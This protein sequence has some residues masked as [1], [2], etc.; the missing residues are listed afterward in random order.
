MADFSNNFQMSYDADASTC[1]LRFRCFDTPNSVTVHGCA[2]PDYEAERVLLDV[3]RTCL[4]LHRLWSFSLAGSDVSRINAAC[5]RV[6]VDRRTA[7]LI[8]AMKDFHEREP[9]FDFTIGPVSY[10]WK[11]AESV[12]GDDEL[13]EALSHVGA[14]LVSVEGGTVVKADPLAQ[15]DVGGAAKGFAADEIVRC[16][17]DAG[18]SCADVD[19]GGNLFM[20][21]SHPSGRDWRVAVRI[22]EGVRAQPVV[23]RVNDKSVVTSGSYERFVEIEGVRYQHIIDVRTGW[24]AR[25]DLVSATV[26]CERSLEADLLATTALVAGSE[27]FSALAARHPD[28]TFV[29]IAE[30]GRVIT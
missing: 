30:D 1:S 11:H 13:E 6:E 12:P 20:V 7:R 15:V 16:L 25:G 19:L 26:A 9:L 28:C 10:L 8:Q 23:L 5:E 29:A 24:P 18:V 2:Q 3:R 14:D 27:G 4:D 21:G 22:P 17:R